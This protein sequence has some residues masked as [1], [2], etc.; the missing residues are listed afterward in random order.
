MRAAV[1]EKYG[2]PEMVRIAEIKKPVPK[3]DEVLVSIHA[4]SVNSG[5][6]RMRSLNVPKGFGIFVRAAF[7]IFAPRNPVLGME[8]AGTIAAIGRDVTNFKVGDE[9]FSSC[10]FGAHAEYRV[11]KQDGALALKPE[12]LS[13]EEAAALSFGGGTALFF[14]KEKGK[15]KRGDKVLINGASGAVG[16]AA[17]QLAKH[18]GAEVTAICSAGNAEL[19]RSLGADMVIDYAEEDF[20]QN[21]KAYDIIMDNVGNAPWLRVRGSLAPT[22]RLLLVVAGMVQMLQSVFVSRKNGRQALAGTPMDSAKT[23]QFLSKLAEE[24]QLRPVIDKVYPLEE[25]VAAHAH[26]ESGRKRGSVV[27]TLKPGKSHHD[28]TT[29]RKR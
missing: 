20:T 1:Y 17:V 8:F 26:V 16:V 14:L 15:I 5:D 19:V 25:I 28:K 27:I 3:D 2:P 6:V 11:A 9:V 29:R 7:G 24:G 22:G 12:N 21:G 18:F 4:T 13:F 10:M 23:L